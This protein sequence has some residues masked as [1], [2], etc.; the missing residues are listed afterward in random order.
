[1]C[2]FRTNMFVL[3]FL[4]ISAPAY[5]AMDYYTWGGFTAIVP[6]LT[7][8][9]NMFSNSDY[10]SAFTAF[11]IF[12]S[13]LGAL[14]GY[15]GNLSGKGVNPH[16]WTIQLCIG[17]LIYTGLFVPRDTLYVY[18]P[19]LNQTQAVGG[20]PEGL[21]FAAGTINLIER[22]I[23]SASDTSASLPPTTA[24]GPMSQL[25][26][27]DQGGAVGLSTLQSSIYQKVTD[28]NATQ[29]VVRYV[30]DCVTFELVRPSTTLTFNQL[31]DPGCGTSSFLDTIGLAANPANYTVSYLE[32]QTQGTTVSCQKAF[33]DIKTYYTN[34]TNTNQAVQSACGSNNIADAAQCQQ[35]LATMIGGSLGITM[36]PGTF[37]AMNSLSAY[38]NQTLLNAG[39]SFASGTLAEINQNQSGQA[40]GWTAGIMNP[41]MIDSFVAYS[42]MVFPIIAL[43]IVTPLWRQ[44]LTLIISMIVW[45]TLLRVLDVT[46]FHMWVTQYQKALA[47]AL[48]NSGMG[49]AAMMGLPSN[50]NKYLGQFAQMRTYVFMFATLISGALFKFGDSTL[51][52]MA[53]DAK[54]QNSRMEKD[55]E[56]PNER[57]KHA[58][59]NSAA[60][61]RTMA[62]TQALKDGVYGATN[63]IGQG[64][65]ANEF[66]NAAAGMGKLDNAGG[67]MGG[68]MRGMMD[69]Q[70][71]MSSVDTANKAGYAES[72][73]PGEA[74]QMGRVQAATATETLKSLGMYGNSPEAQARQNAMSEVMQKSA[75]GM[76][77][78][79]QAEKLSKDTGMSVPDS[80]KAL[81]ASNIA[82]GGAIAAY[83]AQN[84]G[85]D[86]QTQ[87]YQ[88]NQAL[89]HGQTDGMV[90]A[91]AEHGFDLRTASGRQSAFQMSEN[92]AKIGQVMDAHPGATA[93]QAGAIAGNAEGTNMNKMIGETGAFRTAAQRIA[94]Q[95]PEL[96]NND[97]Y[98]HDGHVTEAG[99]LKA[100]QDAGLAK[101][102]TFGDLSKAEQALGGLRKAITLDG[103]GAMTGTSLEGRT[104]SAAHMEH[105]AKYLDAHNLHKSAAGVRRM[106]ESGNGFDFNLST[107]AN[108]HV[109][110]FQATAGG[111]TL[112]QDR[113]EENTQNLNRSGTVR[114]NRITTLDEKGA[115]KI[116]HDFSGIFG[117]FKFSHADF[118]AHGDNATVVG[119]PE[120]SDTMLTLKGVADRTN[121]GYSLAATSQEGGVRYSSDGLVHDLDKGNFGVLDHAM[122]GTEQEKREYASKITEEAAKLADVRYNENKEYHSKA[123]LEVA[124]IGAGAGYQKQQQL[125][126]KQMTAQ[127]E[128]ILKSSG[129]APMAA[130]RIQA[131]RQEMT[132][133]A[134]TGYKSMNFGDK[135]SKPMGGSSKTKR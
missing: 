103:H 68:N 56:D 17:T 27:Q 81:A 91:A 50:A 58:M 1:M 55:L 112:F 65:V 131:L 44:A 135:S 120:G 59:D 97:L 54:M 122:K 22:Y 42:F 6:A 72:V 109:T 7:N 115:T 34:A 94:E 133:G 71:N 124:G 117:G 30:D 45:N 66:A 14:S 20:L 84:G 37:I 82:Q 67:G 51:S 16:L 36:D 77:I 88:D 96:R 13:L 60:S 121:G 24:C 11:A 108:G 126:V 70:R 52:R 8:I 48:N 128:N 123:G 132:K 86:A 134:K 43:F 119:R 63:T 111:H 73:S 64:M 25:N 28:S 79:A 116:D 62:M 61:A 95:S 114:E 12:G 47:T 41:L 110:G 99:I 4:A 35:I 85:L 107:D 90:Q 98:F 87:F 10:H 104:A 80:F 15:F 93:A 38:T 57:G 33:S 100:A 2:L 101:P 40:G 102:Q 32:G 106:E 49:I 105:L 39:T 29:T 92:M 9:G 129:S 21:V 125:A 113:A 3:A 83:W 89:S 53:S 76:S 130:Q 19:V 118:I 127:V 18:D 78:Q 5:A 69:Q 74:A 46:T 26:Y 23:V 75:Q 31:L